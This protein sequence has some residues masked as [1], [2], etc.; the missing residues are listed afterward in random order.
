MGGT[1][2]ILVVPLLARDDVPFQI[3]TGVIRVS[4]V[5]TGQRLGGVRWWFVCPSC[6]GRCGIL[7]SPREIPV[8][9]FACRRCWDLAY[10]SQLR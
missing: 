8:P 2:R 3:G 4:L 9:D 1:V 5:A 6:E 7:F 10:P